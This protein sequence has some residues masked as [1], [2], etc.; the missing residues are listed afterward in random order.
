MGSNIGA[1]T[2]LD[3]AIYYK[4]LRLL[5]SAKTLQ[6]FEMAGNYFDGLTTKKPDEW[7]APLYSALSFVLASFHE[8]DGRIKDSLLNKAQVYIDTSGMRH[9]DISEL[10]SVQAFLYQARIDVSPLER[11]LIYSQKADSEIK[12]A[13]AAN[14]GDPRAYFLYAMNVYYMPKIFG[15]GAEKALPLFEQTAEKFNAFV[16]KMSFMPQWGKQQNMDM[17]AKCKGTL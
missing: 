15:G 8:T 9:P 2:L 16:P 17:I 10:A 14:P 4:G 13:E 12:K 7:L 5:E 6:D 1:Q 3:S 11:G